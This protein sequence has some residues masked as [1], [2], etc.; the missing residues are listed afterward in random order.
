MEK[1]DSKIYILGGLIMFKK[2]KEIA[3]KPITCG[4]Y[5]KLCIWAYLI[6]MIGGM[7]YCLATMQDFRDWVIDKGRKFK[8]KVMFWKRWE[9]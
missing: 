5:G 7:V 4:A 3:G 1:K 2:I 8:H 6:G 9:C